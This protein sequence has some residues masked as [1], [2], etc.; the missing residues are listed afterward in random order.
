M[1]EKPG[2]SLACPRRHGLS[3][4]LDESRRTLSHLSSSSPQGR[5]GGEEWSGRL[6]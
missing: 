3:L 6:C 1:R 5:D 4:C 2:V